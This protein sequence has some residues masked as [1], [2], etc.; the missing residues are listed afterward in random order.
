MALHR[1]TGFWSFVLA[2]GL[3]VGML[4]W[5]GVHLYDSYQA[6]S[7]RSSGNCP[8]HAISAISADSGRYQAML[9]EL[10]RRVMFT[11]D[12]APE[13]WLAD[14]TLRYG[15]AHSD[16]TTSLDEGATVGKEPV[17]LAIAAVGDA[18]DKVDSGTGDVVDS[19]RG[20][21]VDAA[22]L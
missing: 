20:G 13:A 2:A 11:T 15:D 19:L 14:W 9:D 21:D 6:V 22:G 1:R 4:G 16:L 12:L 7:H 18:V 10:D 17:R 8:T 3:T 5:Q